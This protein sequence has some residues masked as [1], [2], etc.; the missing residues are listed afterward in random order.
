VLWDIDH[1]LI[2]VPGVGRELSADAFER[3]TGVAM[4]T[5][6]KIDGITERVIF[7]ET[8]RLHGLATGREDFGRFA[9]ALS[10]AHLVRSAELRERGH[11]LPGAA[12]V[13]DALAAVPGTVQT[14]VTGNVRKVARIKLE[15]FGL[16]RHINFGIGAYGEDSET[17]AEL[18]RAAIGRACADVDGCLDAG[19][20]VIFGDTPADVEAGRDNGVF[21]VGVATG[22]T[23]AAELK[24]AGADCVLPDLQNTAAVVALVRDLASERCA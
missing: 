17:R 22:R 5:Q 4:R 23:A 16:D 24:G 6:A 3:V 15:T 19:S 13:L 9:A 14:V 18:V 11:A 10:H 2:D 21:V 7:R 8:A 12:S 20:A 1:T